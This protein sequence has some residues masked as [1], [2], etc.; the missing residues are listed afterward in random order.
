MPNEQEERAS[1]RFAPDGRPQPEPQSTE[2]AEEPQSAPVQSVGAED[3]PYEN[4]DV[5]YGK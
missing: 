4:P 5:L 2:M 1:L 3:S